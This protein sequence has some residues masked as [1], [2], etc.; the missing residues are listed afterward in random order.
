M[1]DSPLITI[2]LFVGAL[3]I[4]KLYLD[5]ARQAAGGTPNPKALPGAVFSARPA[6]VLGIVGAI[7]LLAFQ[8]V[9]ESLLGLTD[10]QSVLPWIMLLAA[11]A[12]GIIEEVI[13]RGYLVVTKKG[14]AVLWLSILG[15]SLLFSLL[16][17][18]VWKWEDGALEF[19]FTLKAFW[20]HFALFLNSVFFYFCRFN[21]WNPT[22]SLLPCFVA[23]IVM[24]VGVFLVKWQQ[25]YMDGLFEV[26]E[27]TTTA[28]GG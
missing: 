20:T 25:G 1:L 18:H 16:H 10:Q 24:N 2:A 15:F 21:P 19:H 9:G 6:Y 5:D 3:Y 22:R 23:H 12:A 17:N 26:S 13:F 28:L 14:T 27:A 8:T 7:V 11:I 4:L